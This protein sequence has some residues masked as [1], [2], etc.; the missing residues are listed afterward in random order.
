MQSAG[1]PVKHWLVLDGAVGPL[2]S[3]LLYHLISDKGVTLKNGDKLY[4]PK[5]C[6]LIVESPSLDHVTPSL[7]SSSSLVHCS[8]DTLSFNAVINTWLDKA[9][10]QHNL[11]A[12]GYLNRLSYLIRSSPNHLHVHAVRRP[13]LS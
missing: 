9:P 3:E 10:T 2:L 11:S 5:S 12:I 7:L 13:W 1:T 6:Q 4:L 8:R